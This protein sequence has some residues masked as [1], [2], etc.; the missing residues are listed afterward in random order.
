MKVKN[1]KKSQNLQ[2]LLC[3]LTCESIFYKC[4]ACLIQYNCGIPVVNDNF[5]IIFTLLSSKKLRVCLSFTGYSMLK[6]FIFLIV[7]EI[8]ISENIAS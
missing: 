8:S 3:A 7:F 4:M 1:G 5:R 6:P 2:D